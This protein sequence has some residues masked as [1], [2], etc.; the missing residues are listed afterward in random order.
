MEG[1]FNQIDRDD[2]PHN[3][4]MNT[5]DLNNTNNRKQTTAEPLA[6]WKLFL[7]LLGVNNMFDAQ[8]QTRYQQMLIACNPICASAPNDTMWN[9]RNSSGDD[10]SAALQQHDQ[11]PTP[12]PAVRSPSRRWL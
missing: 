12:S 5:V 8:L 7:V 11:V 3:S 10:A 2:D 6:G 9:I 1:L 4:I